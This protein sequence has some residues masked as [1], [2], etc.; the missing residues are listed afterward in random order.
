MSYLFSF[1]QKNSSS[2]N[3][4]PAPASAG[5]SGNWDESAMLD[6]DTKGIQFTNIFSWPDLVK[7]ILPPH[8]MLNPDASTFFG[9][10]ERIVAAESCWFAAK[11]RPPSLPPSSSAI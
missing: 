4:S 2:G 7:N 6:L 11:V 3:W 8:S 5:S 1:A 10:N 9:L